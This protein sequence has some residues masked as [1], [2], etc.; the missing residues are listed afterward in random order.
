MHVK[1]QMRHGIARGRKGTVMSFEGDD[2]ELAVVQLDNGKTIKVPREPFYQIGVQYFFVGTD[3]GDT[4][5]PF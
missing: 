4:S 1:H 2:H 3:G 5:V